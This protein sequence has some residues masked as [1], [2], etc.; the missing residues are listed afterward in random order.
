MVEESRTQ[1]VQDEM[2]R[3]LSFATAHRAGN[4]GFA[5]RVCGDDIR[6]GDHFTAEFRM[7]SKITEE[8]V[9]TELFPVA[10]INLRVVRIEAYHREF[11]EIATNYSCLLEFDGEQVR[12][13]GAVL[14]PAR[15]DALDLACGA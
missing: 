4:N 9:S 13:C 3:Y 11:Q 2:P 8:E 15:I 5:G 14:L 7:E 10:T 12:R 6:L 1:S